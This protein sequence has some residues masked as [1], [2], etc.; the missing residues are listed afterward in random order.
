MKMDS[1]FRDKDEVYV[2]YII[3]YRI[4]KAYANRLGGLI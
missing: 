2:M 3:E 4:I 1:K